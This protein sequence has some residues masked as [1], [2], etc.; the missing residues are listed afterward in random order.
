MSGI[1]A[2]V[3]KCLTPGISRRQAGAGNE[4][5]PG[6]ARRASRGL[7]GSRLN[8]TR[9]LVPVLALAAV[10][11]PGTAS[12]QTED[13][14]VESAASVEDM[15]AAT[16]RHDYDD[17]V[18]I[19]GAKVL[20]FSYHDVRDDVQGDLDPD[21]FAVSTQRLVEQ[22]DWLRRAGYT[23]VSVDQLVAAREGRGTL[24]ARPV[25]LTFD[26]GLRSIYKRVFPLLRLFDYPAVVAV[27]GAWLDAGED[28]TVDYA[29]DVLHGD[30]IVSWA[31]LR[32]MQASG[33]V[34][35]A[36]HSFDMH[37]GV[38]ANPWGNEQ[39]A[40]VTR[41]HDVETGEYES[42]DA[43]RAR[44]RADLETSSRR[45]AEELG[46]APRVIVWPYG[47]Y[48]AT[49]EAIAAELG[50]TVSLGLRSGTQ[51]AAE[52]TGVAR[53]LVTDNPELDEFI[54]MAEHRE[55]AIRP[56]RVIQVD[57]DY[58]YDADPAQLERNLDALI[59]R[60]NYLSVSHVYLQ[61]FANPTGDGT[62]DALYF[63]N[64]HMPVRADLFNR[65]AW[66]LKTRTG[67]DVFAWLPVLAF[68]LPDAELNDALSVKKWE[69]G[70]LVPSRPD[71]RRLSPYEPEARRIILEIFE[72]LARASPVQGLLFHDDAY[73][74]DAEDAA[75]YRDGRLPSGREKTTTLI[76]FTHDLKARVEQYRPNIQTAR[77]LYARVVLEPGSEEWFA[78]SLPLFVEAYDHTALMAMPW[79][80]GA[81]RPERWLMELADSVAAVPG[82]RERVVF[83][84]QSVDWR[85]QR[86]IDTD[87]LARQMRMLQR[88]GFLHF[89]YYPDD[90]VA[91]HPRADRIR[92]AISVERYPYRRP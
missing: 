42:E 54:W 22:F 77:N 64:R 25:L 44:V 67:V 43:Y 50:M 63:P 62:A 89:G 84:L 15:A 2:T 12:A 56:I 51:P 88:A 31:E 4:A 61:A 9:A 71:F 32:E 16:S 35:V 23:P 74:N 70:R 36:S 13:L 1:G 5:G 21:R 24:P 78:Q 58:V 85:V 34:E 86:P 59:E 33:L 39:P 41:V 11:Q 17:P 3:M 60:V 40:A 73:L 57:L 27:V 10:S 29:E 69:D 66:Q 8:V 82:G 6:S 26:D 72:D 46:R 90:F 49:T 19:A 45:I 68:D 20:V 92:P 87:R 81:N 53:M 83:E 48:S 52:L 30:D 80:E 55:S 28:W 18:T 91:G 14:G 38:H 75:L 7:R 76:D 37:R 79:L 65:V 47:E